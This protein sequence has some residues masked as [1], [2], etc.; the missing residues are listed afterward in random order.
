MNPTTWLAWLATIS[1]LVRIGTVTYEEIASLFK[2]HTH[3]TDAE[4]S[5]EDDVVLE[6]LQDVIRANRAKAAHEAGLPPGV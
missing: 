6:M 2:T 4:T 3:G 5:G 1:D